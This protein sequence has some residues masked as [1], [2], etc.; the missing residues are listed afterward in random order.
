MNMIFVVCAVS[1]GTILACQT[2]L[3]VLG[4][5]RNLELDAPDKGDASTE[6]SLASSDEAG[7]FPDQFM[8]N[9]DPEETVSTR[10]RLCSWR[11]PGAAMAAFGLAGTVA[12]TNRFPPTQTYAIAAAAGVVAYFVASLFMRM[13]YAWKW[14]ED[15]DLEDANC[16]EIGSDEGGA[17]TRC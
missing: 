15:F 8:V 10:A 13:F 6:S 12:E 3:S 4:L 9:I 1:G 2:A 5:T 14:D 17:E 16:I 11:S 7:V